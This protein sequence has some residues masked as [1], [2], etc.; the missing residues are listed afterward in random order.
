MHA[1]STRRDGGFSLVELVVVMMVLSIIIVIG[2][3]TSAKMTRIADDEAAQL[4]V[5][6]ATKVQALYHLENG[7]FSDD[8]GLLGA[9]EPMLA[10]SNDGADATIVVELEPA[11]AAT[12]VCLFVQTSSGDWYGLHHSA[13]DGDR[14]ANSA[15]IACTPANVA[16][17]SRESW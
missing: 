16:S 15:P 13:T 12:N 10:Y 3:G 6:T 9:L 4:D 17:W 14:F 1:D 8:A 5:I 2:M 7:V 11:H